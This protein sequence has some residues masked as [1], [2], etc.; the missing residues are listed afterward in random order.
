MIEE[1][2]RILIQRME[3]LKKGDA[4]RLRRANLKRDLKAGRVLVQDLLEEPPEY[5]LRMKV[6]DIILNVPKFGPIKA[7]HVLHMSQ[8][9]LNKTLGELTPRQRTMLIVRLCR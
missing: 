5:A 1:T 4:I 8:L 9:S 3:A 7:N 6:I 2:E